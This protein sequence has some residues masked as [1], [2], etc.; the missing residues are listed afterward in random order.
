MST[1][2][3]RW[4]AGVAEVAEVADQPAKT[5]ED[6]QASES[7]YALG[8]DA[9]CTAKKE[10]NES[11]IVL[12]ENPATPATFATRPPHSD[13]PTKGPCWKCGE[14]VHW[15]GPL[16]GIVNWLGQAIHLRCPDR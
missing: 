4:L 12:R 15:I 2:T 16:E 1:F 10:G 8:V 7:Q 5:H 9:L 14:P 3:N 13:V 11:Q 6:A